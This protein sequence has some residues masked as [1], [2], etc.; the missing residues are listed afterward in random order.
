MDIHCVFLFETR[1][2]EARKK[3]LVSSKRLSE[4][5][6]EAQTEAFLGSLK[7]YH[8]H[9]WASAPLLLDSSTVLQFPLYLWVSLQRRCLRQSKSRRSGFAENYAN[10]LAD[11][12]RMS[13][14][15]LAK[16]HWA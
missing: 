1:F 16:K 11:T 13:V 10:L 3:G 8:P 6:Q 7:E 2:Y 5:M 14:E 4:L 15:D 12:A 9:F